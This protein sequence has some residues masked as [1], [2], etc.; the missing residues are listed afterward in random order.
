[1]LIPIL[2]FQFLIQKNHRDVV[3]PILLI[4]FTFK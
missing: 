4:V 2:I 1:M 3:L